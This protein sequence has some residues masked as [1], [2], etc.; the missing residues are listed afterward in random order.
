MIYMYIYMLLLMSLL[1]FFMSL[2]FLYYKF[3][4]FLYW[5]VMSL[6]S[7]LIEFI[8]LIDWISLIFLST[9]S[10]ISGFVLMYSISYMSEDKTINRFFYLVLMFI[11]SMFLMI[12]SPNIMSLLI[13]WDGLGLV[14]YG[15]IIYYQSWK[16]FNSGMVTVLLNRLGDVG[17]LMMISLLM[18]KGSWN[19]LFYFNEMYLIIL[20]L[21]ISACTKSAQIPFSVWLPMAMAAPTPVS[22]LVHSS[23][24]VTAGVY[25]MIR[26]NMF[27]VEFLGNYLLLISSFTML[28][29]GFVANFENDLKK[30]IAL[31]TLSQL[32]LMMSILS[33]G[34]VSVG[35]FHLI[36]HALFKSLLFMCSGIVIHM[37]LNN[38][39]IRLMGGLIKFYPFLSVIFIFSS[40]SLCGLPFLSGF[41]SKDLIMELFLM[42][43]MNLFSL[44][45]IFISTMFTVS[46]SI[47]LIF[48]VN[49]NSLN[50]LNF[51]M[52]KK[53]DLFMSLSMVILFIFSI[54]GGFIFMN[55]FFYVDNIIILKFLEKNL[56]LMV[57]LIGSLF[58]IYITNKKMKFSL[59]MNIFLSKMFGLEFIL[60]NFY[61]SVNFWA[62]NFFKMD[63]GMIEFI[64]V[65]S[66]K[67]NIFL[68]FF[69]FFS[70]Y[71]MTLSKILIYFIFLII[72]FIFLLKI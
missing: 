63:K 57:C 18:I 19:L 67:S 41:Y 2:L 12:L 9:V 42:K 32:G 21:V 23:T 44:I 7:F 50:E 48:L 4:L 69:N 1:F 35:F 58:G 68:F 36:M 29:S 34:E 45:M 62:Y 27:M 65:F 51:L 15:L 40:M 71:Y 54:L 8:M 24:L 22:S 43:K 28:M 66:F 37:M 17:I 56:V 38:Q 31:S 13:G 26:F 14:S 10:I 30:I 61:K 11:F 59:F 39:D 60:S 16:S 53:E 49:L 72:M 20:L 46:Y 55:M 64:Q 3:S 6:N 70:Y 25:L 47:R 5:S 33:L 52:V